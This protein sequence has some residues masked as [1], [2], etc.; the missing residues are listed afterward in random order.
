MPTIKLCRPRLT[1][2]PS[3]SEELRLKLRI[4]ANVL[5]NSEHEV[6]SAEGSNVAAKPPW[7]VVLSYEF[8]CRKWIYK[9]VKEGTHSLAAAL[10][11]FISNAELREI[12][13]IRPMVLHGKRTSSTPTAQQPAK[14]QKGA[15]KSSKNKKGG[16]PQ[17]QGPQ[18]KLHANT[19]DGTVG[20]R[21]HADLL[22]F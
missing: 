16:Q 6:A 5:A 18:G 2:A 9:R 17:K 20:P 15:G 21:W 14:Y 4:E 13:F 22:H 10:D 11:E 1:K 8:D 12:F 19:M 3:T 7:A